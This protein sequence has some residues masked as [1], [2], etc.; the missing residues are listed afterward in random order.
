MGLRKGMT[1][2]KNGRP[3]GRAYRM[4]VQTRKVVNDILGKNFNIDTVTQDLKKLEARHRL[5]ILI[6]LLNFVLPRPLHE[7]ENLDDQSLVLL[8]EK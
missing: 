3:I 1:N 2:N 6:K 4:S 5:N 7:L 8:I